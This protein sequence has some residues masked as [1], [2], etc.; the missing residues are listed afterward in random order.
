MKNGKNWRIE[1]YNHDTTIV[2]FVRVTALLEVI[3]V[4]MR[5][6]PIL[7]FVSETVKSASYSYSPLI[8]MDY[9]KIKYGILHI[10][11][12]VVSPEIGLL[13]VFQGGQT[14]AVFLHSLS[15]SEDVDCNGE[16]HRQG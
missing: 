14:L 9:I 12:I 13:D 5:D 4:S 1:N 16:H 2:V 10:G 8:S 7:R 3:R 15:Q 11:R 6:I